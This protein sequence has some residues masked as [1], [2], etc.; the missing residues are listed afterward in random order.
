MDQN[1]PPKLLDQVRDTLRVKHYTY[2]TEEAY[3][4]WIR[5][6]ILFHNR[7]HPQ[8]MAEADVQAFLT[9]L[10]VQRHVADTQ[11]KYP[12]PCL[13]FLSTFWRQDQLGFFAS[14]QFTPIAI[15][16]HQGL[17][18]T[19]SITPTKVARLYTPLGSCTIVKLSITI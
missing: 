11:A 2:R 18:V 5:R 15:A 4:D 8:D 16:L 9:H 1:Q 3:V 7:R 19:L 13:T 12:H 6:Y 10:A 14:T 17:I